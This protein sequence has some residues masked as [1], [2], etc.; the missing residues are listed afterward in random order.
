MT[1]G[2]EVPGGALD[3][4]A[5]LARS[6]NRVRILRELTRSAYPRRDL[7]EVTGTSRTT[8]GRI[9]G[10]FEE[11]GWAERTV[12][13]TYAATPCGEHV[14]AAFD[15]LVG[16]METV[17]RLGEAVAW[18]PTDD[19]SIDLRHFRDATVRRSAPN[20]PVEAGRR[21]SDL[22]ADGRRFRTLT[23]LAPPVSVGEAMGA[24]VRDGRLMAE[25]VLA[26]GLVDYL[27]EHPEGPPDWRAY[28]ENGARVYDYDGHV[29]CNLFVVDETVFVGNAGAESTD[30]TALIES[31]N[32]AVRKWADQLIGSYREDATEVEAESFPSP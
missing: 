26:G 32:E 18:L 20:E 23:F 25:H 29:P 10:E 12:D 16:A 7:E 15:P 1:E 8:L 6:E 30:P 2:G 17:E 11:R 24:G 31:R 21:M 3:T 22:L 14:V 9:L 28:L 27:R 19:L 13:G 5:Y 4:I